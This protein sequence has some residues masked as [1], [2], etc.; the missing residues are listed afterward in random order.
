MVLEDLF[1][2]YNDGKKEAIY[3]ENFEDYYLNYNGIYEKALANDKYLVLGKKG[4]GKTLLGEYIKKKAKYKSDWFCEMCSCRSFKMKELFSLKTTDIKPNEY[5]AIWEWLILV[6]ISELIVKEF[7]DV[8]LN[9]EAVNK[10][11]QFLNSCFLGVKLDM[12]KIVE[13]TKGSKISG[14]GSILG[15]IFKVSGEYSRNEISSRNC[16]YLDY[17]DDL[18]NT[19]FQAL[20]DSSSKY[21]LIIDELDDQFVCDELYKSNII[22]LIKSVDKLNIDFLVSGIDLKVIIMLRSDIF[23]VLNDADLNKIEEDNSIRINWGNKHDVKSPLVEM[24]LLKIKQSSERFKKLV[25]DNEAV[26]N[27]FFPESVVCGRKEFNV[28]EYMLGRTYLRPRDLITFLNEV[29]KNNPRD[30]YFSAQAVKNAEKNYSEYLVKEIK[31]EMHGH[32]SE[33]EIEEALMLLRQYKRK[34]FFFKDIQDYYNKNRNV[35]TNIELEKT[36]KCLFDFG[37]IG[38]TWTDK[39]RTY[40]TWA[41]RENSTIDYNKRFT[42]HLGLRKA[43]NI[44]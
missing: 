10:L 37:V 27:K 9:S 2:G 8:K 40:F 33:K 28:L 24:I 20:Q 35:Y 34:S 30:E 32:I 11:K 6:K 17:L 23:Y 36:L 3:R 7:K 22:S 26:L 29:I 38:N 13:V 25:S 31:N 5:A 1:I 4:T 44:S 39:S 19:V 14:S 16:T 12:N 21:T 18:K 42:I 41:Y 15:G 43:F